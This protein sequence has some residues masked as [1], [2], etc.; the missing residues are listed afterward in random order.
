MPVHF[1]VIPH[2]FGANH[3]F[4]LFYVAKAII[5]FFG[6]VYSLML[7]QPSDLLLYGSALSALA[8]PLFAY[9]ESQQ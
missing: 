8:I 9:L 6:Y 1:L 3:H 4:T 5:F 7:G 2:F